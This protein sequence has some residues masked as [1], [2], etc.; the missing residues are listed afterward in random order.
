MFLSDMGMLNL[1]RKGREKSKKRGDESA[2]LFLAFTQPLCPA[3]ELHRF[4]DALDRHDIGG[5][6][7][8]DVVLL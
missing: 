3:A 7:H 6:A 2:P 1:Y 8:V 4:D 5:L